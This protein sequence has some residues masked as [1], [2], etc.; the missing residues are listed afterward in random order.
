MLYFAYAPVAEISGILV[1]N[2]VH[3]PA[4][5]TGNLR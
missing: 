1:D 4:L 2:D 5:L 3:G